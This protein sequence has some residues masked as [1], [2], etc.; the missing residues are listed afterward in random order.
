M[1]NLSAT[2]AHAAGELAGDAQPSA[3]A[4]TAQRLD[5]EFSGVSND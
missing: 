3:C 4:Q 2:A 1:A 5:L